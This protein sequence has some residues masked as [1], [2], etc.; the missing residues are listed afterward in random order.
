MTD[1]YRL[2]FIERFRRALRAVSVEQRR[3]AAIRKCA[4]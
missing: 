3:L 2:V 1:L 4:N